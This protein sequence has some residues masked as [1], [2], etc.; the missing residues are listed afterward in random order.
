VFCLRLFVLLPRTTEMSG[1]SKSDSF[2]FCFRSDLFVSASP[3]IAPAPPGSATTPAALTPAP[4]ATVAFE[5][6]VSAAPPPAASPVVAPAAA[7]PVA[8]GPAGPA[9]ASA[10]MGTAGEPAAPATPPAPLFYVWSSSAENGEFCCFISGC[11]W[12][13]L[14]RAMCF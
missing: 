11:V 10:A 2:V 6:T 7:A 1:T 13:G 8:A 4:R 12:G 5:K 14:G 9:A 3:V